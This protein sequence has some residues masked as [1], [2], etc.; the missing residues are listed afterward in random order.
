MYVSKK[1]RTNK[2]MNERTKAE[3]EEKNTMEVKERRDRGSSSSGGGGGAST[4]SL[5]SSWCDGG[6]VGMGRKREGT[7]DE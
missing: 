5:L 7:N 2:S 3:K 6:D 1:G 4:G